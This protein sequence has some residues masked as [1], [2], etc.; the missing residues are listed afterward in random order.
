VIERLSLH[1]G[2]TR[3]EMHEIL[4]H[5]FL[6]TWKTLPTKEGA[7]EIEITRS[8]TDLNTQEFESFMT[9]VREWAS[10]HLGCWIPEPNEEA[11]CQ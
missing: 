11:T 10:I 6:K 9:D 3:D 4:K 5:K 7:E 2:Y 1:I 8:T